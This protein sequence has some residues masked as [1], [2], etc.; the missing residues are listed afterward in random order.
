VLDGDTLEIGGQRLRLFGI[1]APEADQTCQENA[2]A[3]ACG[4]A[5]K[6]HL[7]A[8]VAGREVQCQGQ[9]V[10]RY[11]RTIAICSVGNSNLNRIMVEQ[12]W[13][14][15]YRQ[16]SD[17][18]IAAELQ[19]KTR[20]LGIWK[21]TFVT[22]SEY[23][24]SRLTPEPQ[25]AASVRHR[26]SSRRTYSAGPGCLI[27]GNHSRRGEWIYH[28]PG[29]PYYDQTKPEAMFCTEEQ[30]VAAGYRRSRAVN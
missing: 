7:Q 28:L 26:A 18:Y 14:I 19:A 15:A 6:E 23:R 1:D 16:Y 21:S 10:D 4:Q 20:G 27:K 24:H 17:A 25:A 13:A 5:S 9:G 2:R 29:M 3:W 11:A 8:L 30:A 12:G 22:P